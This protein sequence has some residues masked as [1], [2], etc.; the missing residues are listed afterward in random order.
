MLRTVQI[1]TVMFLVPEGGAGI[2]D[3]AILLQRVAAPLAAGRRMRSSSPVP[4]PVGIGTYIISIISSGLRS[5]CSNNNV[6]SALCTDDDALSQEGRV[7]IIC[8]DSWQ[9]FGH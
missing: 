1:M 5:W 9:V 2:G 6:L 8:F 4:V 3:V 7:R